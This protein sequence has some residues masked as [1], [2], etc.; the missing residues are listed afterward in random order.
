MTRTLIVAAAGIALSF[1]LPTPVPAH[2][3]LCTS[4]AKKIVELIEKH[5]ERRFWSGVNRHGWL[6]ALYTSESGSWSLIETR[7]DGELTCVV[8]SGQGSTPSPVPP[9]GRKS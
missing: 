6:V 4:S 2:Q 9:R 8:A 3:M 7:P 1:L 5:Q